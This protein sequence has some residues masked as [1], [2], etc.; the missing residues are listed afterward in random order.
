[1]S[2]NIISLNYPEEKIRYLK[3]FGIERIEWA[4][5]VDG[6][7]NNDGILPSM[8]SFLP[9]GTIG[10]ALAHLNLWKRKQQELK[11]NGDSHFVVFE[12]DIILVDDF[13]VKYKES[14]S[15][16]PSDTDVFYFGYFGDTPTMN[17]LGLFTTNNKDNRQ[18]GNNIC[19]PKI[20]FAT[21]A[22]LVTRSGV[23]KLVKYLDGQ[24][25]THI[26]ICIN[27]LSSNK[28]I[29]V[30]ASSPKIA[31]QTSTYNN[32]SLNVGSNQPYVLNKLLSF[33]EIDEYVNGNY[34]TTVNF[35]RIGNQ[36]INAGNFL[37][38]AFGILLRGNVSLRTAHI[39]F[40]LLVSKDITDIT[41]TTINYM[42]FFIPLLLSKKMIKA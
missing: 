4:K 20:A 17:L 23:D 6:K 16:M 13:M 35:F 8:K 27:R 9:Y 19:I 2:F 15:N 34:L 28:L 3:G 30:Y 7:L 22:Y 38:L 5:G 10:C 26:D 11:S 39:I 25:D 29:N 21:H 1:M 37:F 32:S 33:L 14:I 40:L 42:L 41:S 18:I 36:N 24:I 12:D 31:F